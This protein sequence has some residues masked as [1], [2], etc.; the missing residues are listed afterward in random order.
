MKSILYKKLNMELNAQVYTVWMISAL[1]GY[2][3]YINA[4]EMIQITDIVPSLRKAF[5]LIWGLIVTS[6]TAFVAVV[7]TKAG[8]HV[9][10]NKIKP[11]FSKSKTGKNTKSKRNES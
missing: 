11:L 6:A 7:A 5:D 3:A 2:Y 9:W 8:T 10:E 1:C 4:P